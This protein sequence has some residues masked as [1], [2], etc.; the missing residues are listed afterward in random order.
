MTLLH[1]GYLSVWSSPAETIELPAG[2][3]VTYA[4]D[5]PQNAVSCGRKHG[6]RIVIPRS[7][8]AEIG[9]RLPMA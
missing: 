2:A 9:N 7:D 3:A 8:R 5:A 4:R 1:A 6:C